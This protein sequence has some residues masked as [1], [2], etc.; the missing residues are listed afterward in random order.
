MRKVPLETIDTII[1]N[2]NKLNI[3]DIKFEL[4]ELKNLSKPIELI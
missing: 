3:A 2:S 4:P 1:Q